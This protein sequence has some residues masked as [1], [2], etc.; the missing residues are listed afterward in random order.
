MSCLFVCLFFFE[1]EQHEVML[2]QP[3]LVYVDVLGIGVS[4]NWPDKPF[5][6]K[7]LLAAHHIHHPFPVLLMSP[8]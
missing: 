6:D 4:A 3:Y 7:G 2:V 8:I 5:F 1:F